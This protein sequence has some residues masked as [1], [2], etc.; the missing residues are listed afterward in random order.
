MKQRGRVALSPIIFRITESAKSNRFILVLAKYCEWRNTSCPNQNIFDDKLYR[1]LNNL[2]TSRDH[3]LRLCVKSFGNFRI[4]CF[5]F[6]G[7]FYAT[8]N[9]DICFSV[10]YAIWWCE[11]TIYCTRELSTDFTHWKRL[12]LIQLNHNGTDNDFVE[13][14]IM[15]TLLFVKRNVGWTITFYMWLY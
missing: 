9:I 12:N 6:G 11:L 5:G 13:W 2:E 7:D 3:E 14:K 1:K 15:N 8:D 10:Y 4:M